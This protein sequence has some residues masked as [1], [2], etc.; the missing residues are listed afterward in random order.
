[1]NVEIQKIN[2]VE[3]KVLVELPA[4]TVDSALG[5]QYRKLGNSV[6][7]RGFRKG[8]APRRLL[9]SRFGDEVNAETARALITDSLEEALGKLEQVPLGDP[10]FDN[11]PVTPGQPFRFSIQLEV[12]PEPEVKDYKGCKAPAPAVEI[13]DEPVDA[14]LESVRERRAQFVP[15]AEDETAED[16]AILTVDFEGRIDGVPFEGG[17]AKN[18]PIRLGSGRMIPGFEEAMLGMK[19]GETRDFDVNFPED[20]GADHLAGKA[21]TFTATLKEMKRKQKPVLDDELARDEDHEDL[22]SWRQ[23]VR[24]RLL[25]EAREA[26][27]EKR[28]DLVLDQIIASNPFSMPPRLLERE[29][30]R[31]RQ[32]MAQTLSRFG[33]PQETI[34]DA[35][36]GRDE[37]FAKDA[38]RDLR[39]TFLLAAIAKREDIE[40][41]EADV[42]KYLADYAESSGQPIQKVRAQLADEDMMDGLKA[43]IRERQARRKVLEWA[44]DAEPELVAAQAETETETPAAEGGD[45]A[46]EE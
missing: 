27:D 34:Y 19:L 23:A 22:A 25:K 31:R 21:A 16:G 24:E 36:T 11:E 37:E 46:T 28:T 9:E 38:E 14:E 3:V 2:D 8:K 26:A 6:S 30:Q 40:A 43:Q 42:E 18:A 13:T 20:Y 35:I 33:M 45:S 17:A 1:M 41:T 39:A 32:H 7:L 12:R 4:T 10:I 44:V 15:A 5:K 29:V